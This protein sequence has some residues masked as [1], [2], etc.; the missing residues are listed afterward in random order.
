MENIIYK[1]IFKYYFYI[2]KIILMLRGIRNHQ[3]RDFLLPIKKMP[4]YQ[5]KNQLVPKS[6]LRPKKVY[7]FSSWSVFSKY[8][9]K[10]CFKFSLH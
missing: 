10:K 9:I 5:R 6:I 3:D 4:D 2:L 8:A 1:L 7:K